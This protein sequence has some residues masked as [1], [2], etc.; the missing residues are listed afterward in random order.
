M[1][2]NNT[3]AEV[4]EWYNGYKI[5]E[6]TILNPW[7][8]INYVNKRKFDVYWA[9]TSSNDVIKL[10]IKNSL[11]FR[12][13]L[14]VLLK[15]DEIEQVINPNIVFDELDQKFNFDDENALLLS[16]FQRLPENQ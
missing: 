13:N 2:L 15:G 12:K 14:D 6:T 8:I 16:L 1:G 5:G 10:L 9:N 7:S 3:F 11:S 4:L